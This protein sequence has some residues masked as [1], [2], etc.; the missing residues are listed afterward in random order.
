MINRRKML[1]LLGL[2]A[3]S[4]CGLVAHDRSQASNGGAGGSVAAGRPASTG[5]GT[6]PAGAAGILV[7]YYSKTGANY[8]DL[9]L[10]MGNTARIAE[11]IHA[12]VGGDLHEIVP[13]EPYPVDY[14]ETDRMAGEEEA[15]NR[16][17]AVRD[18]LPDTSRYHTV[19]LG[20]P[21]WYGEQPMVVQT[22]M[23]DRNV[24]SATVVPFVTHEGSRFGNTVNVIGDYWPNARVLDGFEVRGTDVYDDLDGAQQNVEAWLERIGF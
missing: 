23:R 8:P 9:N 6:A 15:E 13:A 24:G 16:F 4:L 7:I 10:T 18:E 22:L 17:R 12:R 20:H 11:M 5:T 1:A 19:F 2:G 3:A 21:I 14:D